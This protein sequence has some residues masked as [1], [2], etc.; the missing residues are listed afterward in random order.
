MA[1]KFVAS[2]N[3]KSY[4]KHKLSV[5]WTKDR[6]SKPFIKKSAY[7][8]CVGFPHDI[9]KTKIL[10]FLYQNKIE[11][12]EMILI[13][14]YSLVPQAFLGF[15]S[16]RDCVEAFQILN[17]RF[18]RYVGR[19]SKKFRLF[20]RYSNKAEYA[21]SVEYKQNRRKLEGIFCFFCFFYDFCL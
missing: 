1:T 13:F 21:E 14:K 19:K 7:L 16:I 17:K 4:Q 8:E 2:L 3:N 20:A 11:P 12:K 18:T 6:N 10:Q 9:Q 5:T 15:N